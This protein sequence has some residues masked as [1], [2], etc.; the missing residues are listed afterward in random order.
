MKMDKLLESWNYV[1]LVIEKRLLSHPG[2]CVCVRVC[3]CAC[4]CVSAFA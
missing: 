3:V 4:V 2:T 1:Q